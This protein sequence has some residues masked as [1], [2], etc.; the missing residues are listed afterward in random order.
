MNE[1]H[2]LGRN[3]QQR[4]LWFCDTSR[5]Q[6]ESS[7]VD[8]RHVNAAEK[9]KPNEPL[10]GHTWNTTD[11]VTTVYTNM[12][13]ITTLVIHNNDARDAFQHKTPLI[14]ASPNPP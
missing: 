2:L 1:S 5:L 13:G 14:P 4:V 3:E 6:R 9:T 8:R 12:I 10:C 7:V 11:A